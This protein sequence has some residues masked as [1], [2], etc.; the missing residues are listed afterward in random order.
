MFFGMLSAADYVFLWLG[1]SIIEIVYNLCVLRS[2]Q[3]QR[4]QHKHSWH[5]FEQAQTVSIK[6]ALQLQFEWG[7]NKTELTQIIT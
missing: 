1:A 3:N 4:G 6:K 7:I 5:C 2:T